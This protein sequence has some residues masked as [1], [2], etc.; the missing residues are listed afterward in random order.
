MSCGPATATRRCPPLRRRDV[1]PAGDRLRH[2]RT[3][4]RRPCQSGAGA[5]SG[6]KVLIIT[7]YPNAAGLAELPQG[8]DLLIKPFRRASLIE[9]LKTLFDSDLGSRQ[10]VGSDRGEARQRA[11]RFRSRQGEAGGRGHDGWQRRARPGRPDAECGG[12]APVGRMYFAMSAS[13][14]SMRR[15][16]SSALPTRPWPACMGR[17][18][19]RSL[20]R[21]CMFCH[22]GR[23]GRID[24]FCDTADRIGRA[25]FEADRVREQRLHV[26][27]PRC[28]SRACAA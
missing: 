2:A 9:R 20:A 7:S 4:W 22:A 28:R 18:S 16:M 8:V 10:S 21:A 15:A 17:M 19:K 6:L 13:A 14:S 23:T 3:E 27:V 24:K 12:C 26:L 11:G 1:C 5:A 25:V